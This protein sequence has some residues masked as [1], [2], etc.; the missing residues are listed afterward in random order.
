MEGFQNI[1]Y[2][3]PFLV[4]LVAVGLDEQMRMYISNKFLGDETAL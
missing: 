4:F 1:N 3:A 2:R